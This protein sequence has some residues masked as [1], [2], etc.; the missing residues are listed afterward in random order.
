MIFV[1]A[2]DEQHSTMAP[3][4]GFET[5]YGENSFLEITS[6]REDRLTEQVSTSKSLFLF[7]VLWEDL[8]REVYFRGFYPPLSESLSERSVVT[9]KRKY[10]YQSQYSSQ[11]RALWSVC[12]DRA[13]TFHNL[14][15]LL[16][17]FKTR[18]IALNRELLFHLFICDS[19]C[20]MSCI[21]L[22]IRSFAPL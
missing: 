1:T 19:Q 5:L 4:G 12:F 20:G 15:V 7:C 6:K 13:C 9:K 16:L 22:L 21:M 11:L 14:S 17:P 8:R 10:N 3:T 18:I 2:P